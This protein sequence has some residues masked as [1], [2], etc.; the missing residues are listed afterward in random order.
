MR[1]NKHSLN[2]GGG[3][4]LKKMN[5]LKTACGSGKAAHKAAEEERNLHG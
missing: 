2:L 3:K 4:I 1:S 5:C